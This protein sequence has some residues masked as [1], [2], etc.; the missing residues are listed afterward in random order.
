MTEL[1]RL[2]IVARPFYFVREHPIHMWDDFYRHIYE[3]FTEDNA[4]V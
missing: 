4:K 2:T 1:V 3:P